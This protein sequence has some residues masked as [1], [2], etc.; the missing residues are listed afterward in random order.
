D[1]ILKDNPTNATAR[2]ALHDFSAKVSGT[3]L[4]LAVLIGHGTASGDQTF[5]LPTNVVI[6]RSTDL[7]S[8]GL[9]IA[10]IAT[11]A[12]QAGVSGVCFRMTS[13]RF[14]NPVG[15][16]DMRPHF[17]VD[18][19]KNVGAAFSNSDKIPVSRIDA[20]AELAA[21]EVV[22]LLQKQPHADLRQLVAACASQHRSV[23]GL[24]ATVDLAAPVTQAKDERAR[25]LEAEKAAREAVE[26]WAREA[27]ARVKQAQAEAREAEA[28][29]RQAQAEA[30]AEDELARQLETEKAA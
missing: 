13:P 15:G 29:A 5:F 30:K 14:A 18:V 12:S 26:K 7:L 2:A 22:D 28:R 16:I 8:R 9:S 21:K 20:V 27:E 11:I 19:A 25:Q 10:N 23:Y 4:S 17:D 1:V 6:E 24:A 3:D